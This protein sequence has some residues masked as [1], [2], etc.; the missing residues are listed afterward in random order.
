MSPRRKRTLGIAA[1]LAV[2]ALVAPQVVR[3]IK[4]S[5]EP[6]YEGRAIS[7]WMAQLAKDQVEDAELQQ[8]TNAIAHIGVAAL[9]FLLK[10]LQYEQPRWKTALAA[11]TFG[12][13]LPFANNQLYYKWVTDRRAYELAD[14][15]YSGFQALGTRAMP[16][17]NDLCQIMN[18][19]TNGGVAGRAAMALSRLG[20]NSLPPLLEAAAN[21]LHPACLEAMQAISTIPEVDEATEAAVSAA[22]SCLGLTNKQPT[23]IG[24]NGFLLNKRCP[25]ISITAVAASLVGS[26]ISAKVR[27][28][29]LAY[30]SAQASNAIPT[31]A[32]ALVDPDINVRRNATNVLLIIA[33]DALTKPPPQ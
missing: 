14:A 21:P 24:I 5:L 17:F 12:F 10:S 23:L 15:T 32:K 25:Q 1:C 27:A 20:T 9:P 2:T 31:F 8:T 19:S 4:R 30:S 7:S 29:I 3:L 18:H 13:R 16:A 6:H 11:R 28:Q 26:N 33:P 22:A